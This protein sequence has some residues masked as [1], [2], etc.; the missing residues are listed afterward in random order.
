VV[1]HE[2]SE[3]MGRTSWLNSTI[4][5]STTNY[6]VM[7]LY[8]YAGSGVRQTTNQAGSYFSI[9]NG[10]TNIKSWNNLQ[11]GN[12]GDMGDWSPGT[13]DAFNDNSNSGVVNGL[14]TADL[15]VMNVI[16]WNEFSNVVPGGQSIFP[17]S[18]EIVGANSD[19]MPSQGNVFLADTEGVVLGTYVTSGGAVEID[20]DDVDSNA[21]AVSF[22]GSGSLKLD[23]SVNFTGVILNFDATDQIDLADI[24]FSPSTTLGFAGNTTSGTLTVSDGTHTAQ[25]VLLGQYAASNFSLG[26]DGMGGSIVTAPAV[27]ADDSHSLLTQPKPT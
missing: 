23:A 26:S 9:D 2:V 21:G 15:E 14:S 17:S 19:A 1:E 10:A 25:L 22:L 4:G 18:G 16:G 5:S 11:T 12:S 24:A 13:N 20:A 7:D 27:V 8:R 6:N 3:I